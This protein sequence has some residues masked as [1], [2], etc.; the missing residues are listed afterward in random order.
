MHPEFKKELRPWVVQAWIAGG[1][2]LFYSSFL[3]ASRQSL[4]PM[5]NQI[6][7]GLLMATCL[8]TAYC[9]VRVQPLAVWSPL[10]WFLA[11]YALYY[12]FGPLSYLFG[13]E[14]SIAFMDAYY[15]VEAS[16][17]LHTNTLNSVA[18]L[19]V[20]AG[21]LFWQA[22]I[23]SGKA[24][25]SSGFRS[26]PDGYVRRVVMVFLAIGLPV[27]Y[28][29]SLPYQL[30]LYDFVVPGSVA[31]LS[32]LVGLTLIILIGYYGVLP[33]AYRVLTHVLLVSELLTAAMTFSKLEILTT[34]LMIVLGLYL[35]HSRMRTIVVG[36]LVLCALYAL[37]V[38]FV[39][40]ARAAYDPRGVSS[41]SDLAASAGEYRGLDEHD[42]DTLLA[43]AQIWWTRLSY[44]NAQTFAIQSFDSGAAGDSLTMAVYAFVPRALYPDKPM[45][46]VGDKFTELVTGREATSFSA[47]GIFGEA[48]WNGG[49]VPLMV[50]G[51]LVGVAL[52]GIGAFSMRAIGEG[53]LAYLPV[54]FIGLLMGLRPD[55]WFVLVYLGG[56][57]QAV[58]LYVGIR[59]L[60]RFLRAERRLC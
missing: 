21:V 14:E 29:L 52:A 47:A 4:Y 50:M 56:L 60:S 20:C 57:V 58:V 48:Y 8:M 55:D 6:G 9:V 11:V 17:L 7:P 54:V 25:E 51:I 45:M 15:P 40:F 34:L 13:S 24:P 42:L 16:D 49:W 36:A 10:P 46:S 1:L 26:V 35:R 12:G 19:C 22:G 31:F 38:P 39:L 2:V 37:L 44:A 30:G 33:R 32:K 43:G 41:M 53:G 23:G 3:A 5:A 27:K 59:C 18:L 28:A